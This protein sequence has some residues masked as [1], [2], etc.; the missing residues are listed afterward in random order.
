MAAKTVTVNIKG[1]SS[2][3]ASDIASAVDKAALDNPTLAVVDVTVIERG[4]G[5]VLV[6]LITLV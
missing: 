1:N 6:V 5:G 4:S 2:S 3:Q